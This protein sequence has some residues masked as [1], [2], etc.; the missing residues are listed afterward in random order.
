[1]RRLVAVL[2]LVLVAP[3]CGG[4]DDTPSSSTTIATTSPSATATASPSPSPSLSSSP[5]PSPTIQ[6][7]LQLPADAP[8]EL[9]DPA[10]I[11]EVAGGDLTALAPPGSTV[12][13]TSVTTTPGDPLDQVAFAWRRGDD[14]FAAEQG[15]VVWQRF[16]TDPPWRAVYAFTD[17]PSKGVL[18]IDLDGA[19]LTGDGVSDFLT[20]EQSG[21]SGACGTWRVIT[22]SPGSAAEVFKRTACDTEVRIVGSNLEVREAV[23]RP[24]DPHCCPSAYRVSTLEWDGQAFAE[25]SS[26]TQTT[27]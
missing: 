5:S 23:Y 18:T 16:D 20:L 3:S 6:P 25:T 9:S 1:M 4:R 17:K 15:F 11:T 2:A 10:G 24:N 12:T 8:T 21:G 13:S 19:D 22:P 14:P 7:T 27:S 26:T